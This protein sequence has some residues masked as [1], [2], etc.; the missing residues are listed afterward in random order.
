[1]A[2]ERK[3]ITLN[4]YDLGMHISAKEIKEVVEKYADV[5]N[6]KFGINGKTKTG[7]NYFIIKLHGYPSQIGKTAS[8]I[9]FRGQ[10]IKLT[11]L[12]I[13]SIE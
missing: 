13:E 12:S 2:E 11:L 5:T 10:S 4:V 6:V 8:L 3:L 9:K 7:K 1:M